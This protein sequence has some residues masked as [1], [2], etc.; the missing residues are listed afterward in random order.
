VPARSLEFSSYQAMI[1]CVAAGTGFAIV[2]LS[3]L[4][5]LRATADVRQHALPERVRR[6]RTHLVWRGT[7]SVALARLIEMMKLR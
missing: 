6:N 2:P 5:A 1:A 4:K 7:P 3:V